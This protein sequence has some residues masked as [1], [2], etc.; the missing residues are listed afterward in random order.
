MREVV[1]D[2]CYGKNVLW[3]I[4]QQDIIHELIEEIKNICEQEGLTSVSIFDCSKI[5]EIPAIYFYG[6]FA[7]EQVLDRPTVR[8]LMALDTIPD[9][10]IFC[11]L[12]SLSNNTTLLWTS[13]I[14]QWAHESRQHSKAGVL[15][16]VLSDTALIDIIKKDVNIQYHW[17]WGWMPSQEVRLMAQ[18]LVKTGRYGYLQSYWIDAVLS[19]LAGTDVFL[20]E[21]LITKNSQLTSQDKI[22]EELC[23]YAVERQ[24]DAEAKPKDITYYEGIRELE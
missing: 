8:D 1:R 13:F 23:D 16:V 15:L 9:C 3:F 5:T 10:M 18:T 7:E 12:S 2:L 11:G 4:N 14:H 17:L 22:L 24:W 19:E 21:R 6:Q 20:L